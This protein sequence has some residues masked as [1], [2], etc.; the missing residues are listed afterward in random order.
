MMPRGRPVAKETASTNYNVNVTPSEKALINEA[1][2]LEDGERF[3]SRWIR[4]VAILRAREVLAARVPV[5]KKGR[6][7]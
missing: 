3:P 5:D 4:K 7:R 6:G 1:A 2:T